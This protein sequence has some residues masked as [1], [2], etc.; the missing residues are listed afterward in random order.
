MTYNDLRNGRIS[1]P[2]H[3]YLITSVTANRRPLFKS[4]PVGR[5]TVNQ[6]RKQDAAGETR[7]LAFVVMPDHVH[8]L[9]QL[10]GEVSLSDGDYPL[11]DTIWPLTV[12][13]P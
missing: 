1:L 5:L 13:M 3:A 12:H 8:W 2:G 9:L 7:T 6:M 4:L 10:A 11:W